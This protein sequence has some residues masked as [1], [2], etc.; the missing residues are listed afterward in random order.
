[1]SSQLITQLLLVII[2]LTVIFTYIQPSFAA[3]GEIQ[4]EIDTYA[5]AVSNANAYNSALTT[6]LNIQNSISSNDMAAIS[7][8]L[9]ISIDEVAVAQEIENMTI[10]NDLELTSLTIAEATQVDSSSQNV[11]SESFSRDGDTS[12]EGFDEDSADGAM[13]LPAQS[14]ADTGRLLTQLQS[15]EFTISVTG[16]FDSL[17]AFLLQL[18]A[19]AYPL[20]VTGLDITAGGSSENSEDGAEDDYGLNLTLETYAFNNS[21]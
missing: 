2:S 9:P 1:M 12:R 16:D 3:L 6:L 4:S 10:S 13:S 19:N 20:K 18:E 7:R 17:Q 8:Y 14:S 21:N 11:Q 5:E 15:Q